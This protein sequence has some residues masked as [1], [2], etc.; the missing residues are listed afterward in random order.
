MSVSL[1]MA[2][3]VKKLPL[4]RKQFLDAV[5]SLLSFTALDLALRIFFSFKV[6][7]SVLLYGT[8]WTRPEIKKKLDPKGADHDFAEKAQ[9]VSWHKNVQP[10]YTK[11]FPNQGR[12]DY[13][14]K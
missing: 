14:E 9:T 11:Y 13:D 10:S 2:S 12:V 3:N 5:A 4:Q 6:G 8:P 7:P 1:R